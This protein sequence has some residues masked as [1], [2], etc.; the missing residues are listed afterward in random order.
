LAGTQTKPKSTAKDEEVAEEEAKVDEELEILDPVAKAVERTL[1]HPDGSEKTFIQHELAFLPKLRFLRLLSGTIR[2]AAANEQGGVGAFISDALGS[3]QD[4][5]GTGEF[6][7]TLLKLVELVP[8][9]IDE[10]YVMALN[11]KP[12]DQLWATE[13]LEQIDDELGMDILDTFITQNGK[14]LRNFFTQ[15]LAKA[16]QRLTQTVGPIEDTEQA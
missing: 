7:E 11:V 14:A 9:F 1:T 15:R 2:V 8:D 16:G 4:G 13:A 3:V 12:E 5:I 6:L 10:A